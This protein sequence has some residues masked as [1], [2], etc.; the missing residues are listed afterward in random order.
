MVRREREA[1]GSDSRCC[2]GDEGRPLEAGVQ[3]RASNQ[4]VLLWPKRPW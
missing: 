4:A 3:K 1:D 2:R